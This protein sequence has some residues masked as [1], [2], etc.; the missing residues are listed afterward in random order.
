[1]KYSKRIFVGKGFKLSF[2]KTLFYSKKI[3]GEWLYFNNE[4]LIEKLN[5]TERIENIDLAKRIKDLD[6]NL[7]KNDLNE[8]KNQ[9]ELWKKREEKTYQT[10]KILAGCVNEINE[11][12]EEENNYKNREISFFK[13]EV[14]HQ[15]KM[16]LKM[17]MKFDTLLEILSEKIVNNEKFPDI[18]ARDFTVDSFSR[19]KNFSNV[20][21]ILFSILYI[22]KKSLSDKGMKI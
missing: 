3:K 15:E 19:S 1:M 16:I 5:L 20:E 21:K 11:N 13:K 7:I 8:L 10:L 12:F 2:F 6:V 4:K 22:M 17:D 18:F 9:I 14:S